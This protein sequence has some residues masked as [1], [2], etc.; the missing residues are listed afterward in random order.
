MA[1]GGSCSSGRA[2]AAALSG[3]G[4]ALAGVGFDTNPFL[5][6]A[7]TPQ[8][9]I[10]R[11]ARNVGF[12]RAAPALRGLLAGT[13]FRIELRYDGD[14]RR[15]GPS[16]HIWHQQGGIGLTLVDVGRMTIGAS[17]FVSHYSDAW[18]ATAVRFYGFGA[19]ADVATRIQPNLK[20][21]AWFRFDDRE[22]TASPLVDS[23]RSFAGLLRLGWRLRPGLEVGVFAE[24]MRMDTDQIP[25]AVPSLKAVLGGMTRV[26][27]GIDAWWGIGR[28]QIS[29]AVWGGRQWME[30]V[31]PP[32]GTDLSWQA[33]GSVTVDVQVTSWLDAS[34]RYNGFA[35]R[36]DA[37]ANKNDE[38]TPDWSRHVFL[39]GLVGHVRVPRA[40]RVQETGAA[41]AG[42]APEVTKDGVTFR[43][44]APAAGSVQVVGSWN[45]WNAENPQVLERAG[46][47][48]QLHVATGSGQHRYRFLVDGKTVRP[49]D[50]PR[51]AADDFGGEDGI[52]DVP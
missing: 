4:E 16:G 13:G 30:D 41:R 43:L 42:E 39:A 51:Y 36:G 3:E 11:D 35:N 1:S 14:L 15:L 27:G 38:G 18:D 8:S 19:R 50:A 47:M 21:A 22:F 48:W 52:V 44:R 9:L 24:G 25:P 26:H 40:I 29:G 34:L 5:Q 23:D 28:L 33:G 6:V 10:Y 2:E 12:Q 45:D 17:G 46:E 37:G 32:K 31:T 20:L 49:P 7:P